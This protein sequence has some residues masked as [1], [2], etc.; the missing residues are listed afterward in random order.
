L[1]AGSLILILPVNLPM[2]FSI[3]FGGGEAVVA[4]RLVARVLEDL[5]LGHVVESS[6]DS[7]LGV[8]EEIEMGEIGISPLKLGIGE[9]KLSKAY[10][11]RFKE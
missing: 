3:F 1:D 9:M 4:L 11:R 7:P 8:R 10:T 6:A 5:A 2:T